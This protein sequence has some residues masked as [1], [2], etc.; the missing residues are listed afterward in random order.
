M[1]IY[2]NPTNGATNISVSL[3]KSEDVS[4]NIFNASGQLVYSIADI[5]KPAGNHLFYWDGTNSGVSVNAGYYFVKVTAGT[6]TTVKK[7]VLMK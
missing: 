6:Q 1:S 2:P 7:L 4:I 5:S 3:D